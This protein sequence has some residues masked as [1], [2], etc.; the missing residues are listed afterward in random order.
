[1]ER[2]TRMNAA[3]DKRS[4]DPK[5]DFGIHCVQ[6]YM[7]LKGKLGAVHFTFS[8]GMFLPETYDRLASENALTPQKFSESGDWF[9]VNKPMGYDVGYH[10]PK[11]GFEGQEVRWPTKMRKT[12]PKPF[13]VKFDKIGKK[14]PVCEWIGV[15][16]Y[17]DGSALRAEE[18][19]NVLLKEGSEK[20]W[21][22]LEDEYKDRFG[23]LV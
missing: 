5:K 3:Y 1:M 13:D 8:T 23:K 17:T 10:S 7:V 11:P 9:A 15:P 14:P 2:I 4:K 20:I 12:G 22:M 21:E 16:C 18:W 6:V 19:M